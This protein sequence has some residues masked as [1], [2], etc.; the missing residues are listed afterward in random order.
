MPERLVH[1]FFM[2]SSAYL[3]EIFCKKKRYIKEDGENKEEVSTFP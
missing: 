2:P 3:R 1:G